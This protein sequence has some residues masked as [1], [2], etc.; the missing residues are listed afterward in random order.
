[1]TFV[2]I[3]FA[4][5]ASN[6]PSGIIWDKP[7]E[8]QWVLP[9]TPE[10]GPRYTRQLDKA[11]ITPV[12]KDRG[13]RA[14]PT[15]EQV[16]AIEGG[17]RNSLRK[18]MPG[19]DPDPEAPPGFGGYSLGIYFLTQLLVVQV[20]ITSSGSTQVIVLRSLTENTGVRW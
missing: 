7:K 2:V 20:V 6:F 15:P 16:A 19:S 9:R 12:P 5:L 17:V 1:M 14:C 11:T 3:G 18:A 13:S 4:I 8:I 10:G